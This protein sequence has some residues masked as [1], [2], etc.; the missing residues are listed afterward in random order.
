MWV[1]IRETLDAALKK[2]P[3]IG[4]MKTQT[5]TTKQLQGFTIV[6]YTI[7]VASVSSLYQ[8]YCM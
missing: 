1:G 6:L 5:C 7:S 3:E 2:I 8:L 4:Q